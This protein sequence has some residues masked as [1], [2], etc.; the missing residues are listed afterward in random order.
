MISDAN[1]K[2][3]ILAA[4]S[5]VLGLVVLDETVVGVALATIQ[6][7]LAMSQVASHWVVNAYLLTFTC[8]VAV[9]GRLGDVLGHRGFFVVGVAVFGLASLAAG[10]AQ[11]GAWLIAARALQGIGAAIVFPASWAM[12]T[13]IFP[14]E[15]RGM[16]F[17]IQTTVG[18]LFMSMGPLLGG[19]FTE[20]LSWRWI[21]WINLPVAAVIVA[22]VWL[23]WKAPPTKPRGPS[24]IDIPGLIT[25][26]GGLSA[27]VI[28][29]MQGAEWGWGAVA[30]LVLLCSGVVLLALFVVWERRTVHP[31]IQLGLL[32][33][34]TFTG[35]VLVFFMFQFNKVAVFVF[36]ALYLQDVLHFS[37]ID[38][39]LVV[40]VA[41][42]PTLVTSL[43]SGRAADRFGSRRPL[44]IGMLLNGAALVLIAAATTADSVALIV[45]PL[46]V[47][48]AMLPFIAVSARRALMNTVPKTQQGEASGVNLTVQ[49]L[50]G[51]VGMALCG[52]LLVATGTYWSL[53][54]LTGALVFALLVI[55]W[56][57]VERQA[58]GQPT[59]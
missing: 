8:F 4:M 33:S 45:A 18:G 38:A 51:T 49:M 24:K 35:A 2:W 11:N 34:G 5:G 32:R 52:A 37:P 12:M 29:L 36:V 41:V 1:R 27:L 40:T 59:G 10:F 22:I 23:A 43:V 25:L 13:S 39:G 47:W 55:A 19:L 6:P 46:V 56:F 17:G 30:T 28:V 16:A 53:F 20:T 15:Q 9:G 21:F 54:L 14:V 7:D 31:L 3:W 42:V 44:F 50:G 48:G 58:D 57:T 26:V